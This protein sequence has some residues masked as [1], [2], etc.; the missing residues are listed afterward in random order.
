M[1]SFNST[2]LIAPVSILEF[3][4]IIQKNLKT[5]NFRLNRKCVGGHEI[6]YW[7]QTHQVWL[8]PEG[9]NKVDIS[10]LLRILGDFRSSRFFDDETG[11][12]HF[13]GIVPNIFIRKST[14]LRRIRGLSAIFGVLPVFTDFPA[15]KPEVGIFATRDYFWRKFHAKTR[16]M[17][18]P[19]LN[20]VVWESQKF[21]YI[22]KKNT[23]MHFREGVATIF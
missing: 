20:S 12:R 11:S 3:L 6:W 18:Y 23:S 16:R 14:I 17:S 4:P 13:Q 19:A 5:D 8:P 21:I 1:T 15:I 22:Q 2:S 7:H 9:A 10:T